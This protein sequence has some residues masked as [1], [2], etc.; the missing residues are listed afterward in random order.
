MDGI[1][2]EVVAGVG[3]PPFMPALPPEMTLE[4]YDAR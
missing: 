2:Y 3:E 1:P 4:E